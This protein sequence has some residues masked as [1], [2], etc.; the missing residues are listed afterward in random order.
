MDFIISLK[1]FTISNLVFAILPHFEKN[2]KPQSGW[3]TQTK[4]HSGKTHTGEVGWGMQVR[5]LQMYSVV[6]NEIKMADA[7]IGRLIGWHIIGSVYQ[8]GRV[9]VCRVLSISLFTRVPLTD[10]AHAVPV[11]S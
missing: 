6:R 4:A 5:H 10:W 7:V 9:P 1:H 2:P 3:N 8:R 11:D